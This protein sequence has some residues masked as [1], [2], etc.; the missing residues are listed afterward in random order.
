M[1]AFRIVLLLLLMAAAASSRMQPLHAQSIAEVADSIRRAYRIPELGYAVISSDSIIE[2]GTLGVRK[3]GS[4]LAARPEDRFH[5]GSNTKSVT[6]F[7]AALLVKRGKIRWES[8]FFDLYPEL[9][10]TSNPGYADITLRDLLTHRARIAAC[11][12]YDTFPSPALFSGTDSARRHRFGQILLGRPPVPTRDGF[13]FSNGGYILA[14]LMLERA[15]GRSWEHLVAALGDTLGIGFGISYPNVA[16]ASQTWGHD[17]RL[18][19]IPP[20]RH[21]KEGLLS[22]AGNLNATVPDYAR[23]LQE[24]LRG[25]NGK[26]RLLSREEFEMLHFGAPIYAIGWERSTNE[27]EPELSGHHGSAGNFCSM[28]VVARDADRAYLVLTNCA[29]DTTFDAIN[30]LVQ[31]MRARYER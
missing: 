7:I 15:A 20:R 10:A 4:R 18:T 5:L 23:F 1:R 13:A 3:V 30:A 8:R 31:I 21:F 17:G 24:H 9:R 27:R 2:A 11:L 29:T 16:D 19:P 26:S 28:A 14:A 12:I 25:L 22:A 6:A